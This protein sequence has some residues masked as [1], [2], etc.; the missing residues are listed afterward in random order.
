M[1]RLWRYVYSRCFYHFIAKPKLRR[2]FAEMLARR[3]AH[4]KWCTD[5]QTAFFKR[6]PASCDRIQGGAIGMGQRALA[7]QI[8]DTIALRRGAEARRG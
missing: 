5:R 3:K 8:Q 4:E 7:R 6:R 2:Q 1:R